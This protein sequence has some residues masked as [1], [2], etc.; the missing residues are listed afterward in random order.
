MH[1]ATSWHSLNMKRILFCLLAISLSI[2]N[3]YGQNQEDEELIKKW[4]WN[5]TLSTPEKSSINNMTF[6][7]ELLLKTWTTNLGESPI[8][9]FNKDSLIIYNEKNYIY[10]VNFDS[11]R[12]FTSYDHPGDGIERGIISKLTKDSLIIVWTSDDIDRYI[13]VK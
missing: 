4:T 9:T 11:L 1:I 10:S 7:Q 6:P 3:S 5:E 12:I 2:S 8:F 13:P